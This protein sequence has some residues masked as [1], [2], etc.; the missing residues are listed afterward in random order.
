[1]F[2]ASMWGAGFVKQAFFP[3]STRPQFLVD[4]WMPQGTHIGETEAQVQRLESWL[5]EQEGVQHVT[6]IVGR[7]ALRFLLTY[8]PE[9][10]NTAYAQL[11]VDVEETS[12]IPGFIERLERHIE[13]QFPDALGY[14]VKFELGP[15]GKGKIQARFTGSDPDELRRLATQAMAIMQDQPNTKSVR[16]DWRERVKLLRP[17]VVEERANLLGIRKAEVS[18]AIRR[19][20][21]GQTIGVYRD[22]DTLV[23]IIVR[24][25]D[26][27]RGDI[28][29]LENIQIWS[30][31]AGR[32]VP[33]AQVISGLEIEYEDEIL[34][35]LNR[36]PM[37]TVY[38]DPIEGTASELFN[39]LRPQIAA[40]P[41]PDGY[42]LLWYGEYKD[43]KDANQALG[44]GVPLF[45]L[46]M[47]LTTVILFNSI[48]QPLVIWMCV[49]LSLIGMVIGLLVTHQPFTFMAL[50]GAISLSGMLIKN[51]IVMIDELNAQLG[52]GKEAL[53]AVVDSAASRLLPVAMAASTTALG[54]IP[55][56]F[57]DFFAAMG[58]TIVFGLLF[59][60][61]LTLVVLPVFYSIV[62]RVKPPAGS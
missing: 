40:I 26:A 53:A 42:E 9:Q 49:P 21:E 55:L 48:R 14:G 5:L 31:V 7:G 45:A 57:D 54:M 10:P 62:F 51:A 12:L 4:F 1:M 15:G 36:K 23:P 2:V 37:I 20:F 29:Q 56:L 18:Q 25:T 11:L 34:M 28:N 39:R 46:L 43:S 16:T 61:L 44:K 22:G 30:P 58:V 60:T 6:S 17:Q 50:L 13:D 59:A 52:T 35:R 47:V 19:G 27:E 38:A 3:P 24:A 32:R 41:L 33:L 8:F